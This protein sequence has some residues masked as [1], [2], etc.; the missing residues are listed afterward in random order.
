MFVFG[1]GGGVCWFLIVFGGVGV[2]L[3][4]CGGE[5][6]CLCL[7]VFVGGGGP[8]DSGKL[9]KVLANADKHR[10]CKTDLTP[11][12]PWSDFVMKNDTGEVPIHSFLGKV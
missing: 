4:V 10:G 5:M 3:V 11:G 9:W 1:G 6:G 8:R 7:L 12:V 2:S